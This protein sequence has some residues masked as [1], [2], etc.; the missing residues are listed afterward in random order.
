MIGENE[1]HG[2]QEQA[3]VNQR[4]IKLITFERRKELMGMALKTADDIVRLK[5]LPHELR[6]FLSAISTLLDKNEY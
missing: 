5:V 6:L 3:F 2:E 4:T 1:V